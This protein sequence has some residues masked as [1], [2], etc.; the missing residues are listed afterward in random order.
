MLFTHQ[1]HRGFQQRM[2][3]TDEHRWCLSRHIT[4]GFVET[5]ALV[6]LQ[7]GFTKADDHI[8]IAHG[9]WHKCDLVAA[10][11]TR[12]H[13][14][15]DALESF[16]E[17]SLDK[18]R[19]QFMCFATLHILADL[20]DLADI[21]GIFCE[22][23]FFDQGA[24]LIFVKGMIHDLVQSRTHGRIVAI[25]YS[26]DEQIA[27]R[28]IVEG[29]LAKDIKNLSAQCFAF[30]FKFFEQA[31]E[32]LPFSRF[33]RDKVPEMAD[34]RLSDT[35]DTTEA[36]FQT[37]WIPWQIVVNH[38]MRTLE[39]DPFTSRIGGDQNARVFILLEQFFDF[40]T[41]VAEHAAMDRDDGFIVTK[42]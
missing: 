37:I 13:T 20:H 2:P 39:V 26:L 35:M 19:L 29:H 33:F 3:R 28:T 14:S 1:V 40:T 22:R 9:N 34:L 5:D 42:Q 15:A 11:F 10:F 27:Q 8:S 7:Y 12:A 24:Q 4:I 41:F 6:F 25:A 38:E 21:H 30:F 23:V 16:R 31:L 32:D 17:E 18:M 36:L